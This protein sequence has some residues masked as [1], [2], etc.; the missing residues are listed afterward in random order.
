MFNKH[1]LDLRWPRAWIIILALILTF[2]TFAIAGMEVGNT[3]YD[4]F[5]S[6]AFGGFIAFIP[7]IMCDIF[8]LITGKFKYLTF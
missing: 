1:G 4:L 5:R 2:L 6:T 7:L 3:V 8:I